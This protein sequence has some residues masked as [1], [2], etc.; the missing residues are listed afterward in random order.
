MKRMARYIS[1]AVFAG[2]VFVLLFAAYTS[3][4]VKRSRVTCTGI[5]VAIADSL[6]NS[7]VSRADVLDCLK[8]EYGECT[9]RAL[10][11]ID[12]VKIEKAVDARSAVRKSEAYLTK[13]GILHVDV[14]QREPIVRFQKAGGGF[15]A[16]EEGFLFPLQS[17]YTAHVPVID[18]AIPLHV[19]SG[20]KGRPEDEKER[21]W[22][23]RMTGLI[24]YMAG[25]GIWAQNIVQITV[26]PGGDLVMIPREG[27][28]KFLFGQPVKI[29]EKFRKMERYY[30]GIVPEK[31]KDFYSTVNL[32]YDRQIICRQ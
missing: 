26:F 20:Y 10:D 8:K 24:K 13:D 29:K 3:E 18:G 16:D 11:S 23:D 28:E 25:S 5:E 21:E 4:A 14:T 30:T 7:F 9:G 22:T 27:K 12:L 31:G 1:A 19:D 2:L 32:K 15:Y 17:T 6:R